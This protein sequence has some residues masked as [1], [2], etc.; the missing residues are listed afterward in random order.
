MKIFWGK[1]FTSKTLWLNVIAIV[2]FVIQGL[3]GKAWIDP[4]YQAVILGVL[5][6]IAR[7]LTNDAVATKVK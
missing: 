1:V 6:M 7:F 3:E 4:V 5:N 2:I